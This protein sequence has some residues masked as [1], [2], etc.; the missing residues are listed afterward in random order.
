MLRQRLLCGNRA[1]LISQ[2]YLLKWQI[3][4]QKILNSTIQV[5]MIT[6]CSTCQKTDRLLTRTW[7]L[8]W[9]MQSTEQNTTSWLTMTYMTLHRDLY[10]QTCRRQM[11]RHTAKLIHI[12]HSRQKMIMIKQKNIW[13]QQWKKWAFLIRQTSRLLFLQLIQMVLRSRLKFFRNSIRRTLVLK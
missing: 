13:M 11:T 7:D 8:L 5:Q 2:L 12:H 3:S 4:I 6:S 9:T 10:F 1:K